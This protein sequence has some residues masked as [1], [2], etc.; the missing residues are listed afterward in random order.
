[1]I[2]EIIKNN[3]EHLCSYDIID[4]DNCH[5][6]E[7]KEVFLEGM[8]AF[9]KIRE[10]IPNSTISITTNAPLPEVTISRFLALLR[11]RYNCDINVVIK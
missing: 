9:G 11:R 10:L 1:M 2:N 6:Q 5:Y 7:I 3:N 4:A 8:G